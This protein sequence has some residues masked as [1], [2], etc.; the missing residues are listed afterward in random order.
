MAE[1]SR[2]SCSE[3]IVIFISKYN[4]LLLAVTAE[5]SLGKRADRAGG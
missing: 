3:K 1:V 4:Q 2:T 5:T